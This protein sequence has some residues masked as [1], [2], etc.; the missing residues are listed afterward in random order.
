MA[1]GIPI[2]AYEVYISIVLRSL[3]PLN[4]HH[5]QSTPVKSSITTAA[6]TLTTAK[7]SGPRDTRRPP[8]FTRT[9]PS[10]TKSVSLLLP[11]RASH[12]LSGKRSSSTPMIII[13]R[14]ERETQGSK[15]LRYITTSAQASQPNTHGRSGAR[16]LALGQW[17]WKC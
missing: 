17:L 7:P 10:S 2:S 6:M 8:S 9:S 4:L 11:K 12:S 3:T 14:Y 1:D 16:I 5:I 13:S 15:L